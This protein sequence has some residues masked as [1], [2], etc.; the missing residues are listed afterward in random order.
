MWVAKLTQ[1]KLYN[2]TRVEHCSSAKWV[3]LQPS[4]NF[5]LWAPWPSFCC[6]QYG[7]MLSFTRIWNYSALLN[8]PVVK[9]RLCLT[10]W[11]QDRYPDPKVHAWGSS[12]LLH[13]Q[14]LGIY[15]PLR[16]CIRGTLELEK[17]KNIGPLTASKLNIFIEFN[18]ARLVYGI[19]LPHTKC[20]IKYFGSLMPGQ[21]RSNWQYFEST[22]LPHIVQMELHLS[23]GR[24]FLPCPLLTSNIAGHLPSHPS[25]STAELPNSWA[26]SQL[27]H[28]LCTPVFTMQLNWWHAFA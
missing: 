1:F 5:H 23:K 15:Y 11:K 9:H 8:Q 14:S 6:S 3:L 4:A 22:L 18:A 13:N 20:R 17:W 25:I 7:V 12:R 24:V 21:C 19:R 16:T 10:L 2:C 27:I 26:P 28:T